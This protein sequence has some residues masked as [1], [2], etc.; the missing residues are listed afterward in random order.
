MI[1]PE[2]GPDRKRTATDHEK[3]GLSFPMNFSLTSPSRA[4]YC[5]GG[6]EVGGRIS[7]DHLSSVDIDF[8]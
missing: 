6:M 2:A 8:V 4:G 7:D 1:V 3:N 5:S